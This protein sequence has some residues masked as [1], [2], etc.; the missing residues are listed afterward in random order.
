MSAAIAKTQDAM[1]Q[2][3][4]GSGPGG[5]RDLKSIQYLLE[6]VDKLKQSVDDI[7]SCARNELGVGSP[8][9]QDEPQP[10]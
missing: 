6:H 7:I 2:I 10:D 1:L 4:L 9:I 8:N 3:L 5:L